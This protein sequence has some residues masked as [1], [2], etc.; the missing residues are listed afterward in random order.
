MK[1]SEGIS[2]KFNMHQ[3]YNEIINYLRAKI[4]TKNEE[5]NRIINLRTTSSIFKQF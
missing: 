2:N 5:L 4:N 3:K 1:I